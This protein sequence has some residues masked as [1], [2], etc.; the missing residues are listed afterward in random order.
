MLNVSGSD[1]SCSFAFAIFIRAIALVYL[2][3]F[4]SLVPQIKALIGVEGISPFTEYLDLVARQLGWERFVFVP[5]LVWAGRDDALLVAITF[6]GIVAS[7]S[8]IAG[9]FVGPCLL[10]LWIFYL[11]ILSVGQEFLSFQWDILLLE[12]GFLS[13]F[14]APWSMRSSAQPPAPILVWL[15]R[16]LLFRLMFLSGIVKLASGDPT[17]HT[18]TALCFHYETQPLPTPFGWLAHQLPVWFQIF[19]CFV[20]FV[21][22]LVVPFLIFGTRKMRLVAFSI[23]AGFQVLIM[24][25]G[26]YTFFNFLTVILC[27][28][29]LDDSF[30]RRILPRVI[31]SWLEKFLRLPVEGIDTGKDQPQE[32]GTT[33]DITSKESGAGARLKLVMTNGAAAIIIFLTLTSALRTIGATELLLSPIRS[34]VIWLSPFHLVNNYGLFAVMTTDRNEI[35][36]EG[37]HDGATWLA[38]EFPFKPGDLRRPPPVVA[39]YQPRL[40]WQMWFAALSSYADN[41]WFVKFVKKLLAGDKGVDSLLSHNPFPAKPPRYIRARLYEYHMSDPST[42]FKTGNW[43]TRE[44]RGDY[45]PPVSLF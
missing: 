10:F 33:A 34:A 8:A 21:I 42:L 44:A 14:L 17:W 3:A 15:V 5:T 20:M 35:I 11:S 36:L 45:M 19:S 30:L 29:L 23:L 9:F 13:I 26:N 39:P 31:V 4:L 38:Y 24:L 27:V 37:S 40:D 28:S 2:I 41:P 6:G 16:L 18:M 32:E 22:E 12:A 25:T 43:W 7:I 1:S